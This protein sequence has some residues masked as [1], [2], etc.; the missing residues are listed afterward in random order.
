[1][2]RFLYLS[3]AAL[4][5]VA[6]G[7][8]AYRMFHRP[9][10][11][12]K[13]IPSNEPG[14]ASEDNYP[15]D[16][17]SI[18]HHFPADFAAPRLLQ[19]FAQWAEQQTWGSVGFFSVMGG[20][21]DDR[22]IDDGLDLAER[23]PAFLRLP[24]GSTVGYW[25]RDDGRAP[26]VLVGSEGELAVLA[27]DLPEFLNRLA[28]TA[29]P[30]Q[31]ANF[32]SELTHDPDEQD[33]DQPADARPRLAQWLQQKQVWLSDAELARRAAARAVEAGEKAK[34]GP[35]T[36]MEDAS[37]PLQVFLLQ[38]WQPARI[39]ARRQ[40]K[41][42]QALF[43]LLKQYRPKPKSEAWEHNSVEVA[44]I[45]EQMTL[46]RFQEGK[47]ISLP[48][49][50]RAKPLLGA[51]REASRKLNPERGLWQSATL[52]LYTDQALLIRNYQ[53]RPNPRLHR[54]EDAE[55]LAD[56]LAQRRSVYWGAALE[57]ILRNPDG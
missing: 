20:R 36:V 19:D 28:R 42:L 46:S 53:D 47:A 6:L 23:F 34:T 12:S 1:M 14:A 51:L 22:W 2:S 17:P 39:A 52:E 13:A 56:L 21:M 10:H 30:E 43:Q 48:E 32:P 24:E 8:G 26:I 55:V 9:D 33:E 50:E 5:L 35:N 38:Q 27:D 29:V 15:V 57:A 4:L 25:R 37:N 3:L 18:G 11:A 54:F 45:G 31:W 7:I 44:W 41:E 40:N 49:I 16:W